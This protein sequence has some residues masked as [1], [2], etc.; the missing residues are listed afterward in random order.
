V[1]SQSGRNIRTLLVTIAG[2]VVAGYLA[3][4]AGLDRVTAKFVEKKTQPW[5]VFEKR[6]SAIPLQ[7][8]DARLDRENISIC[9]RG[10]TEWRQILL[11]KLC[12]AFL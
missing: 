2:I 6:D 9:N 4:H 3:W 8:L 10:N 7:G 5:A 11:E 12:S 1:P